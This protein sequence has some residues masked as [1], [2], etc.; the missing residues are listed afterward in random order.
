MG[1]FTYT[2]G[3]FVTSKTERYKVRLIKPKIFSANFKK[4]KTE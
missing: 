3:I 1:D 2:T 4:K